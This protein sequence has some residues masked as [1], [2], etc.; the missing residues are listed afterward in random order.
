MRLSTI[1]ILLL[2][3]QTVFA[4]SE[5]SSID[6]QI[7]KIK[8][9]PASERYLLVNELKKQIAQMNALEQAKAVT[10]YQEESLKAQQ[11]AQIANDIQ[12]IN[13]MHHEQE[14]QIIT[15]VIDKPESIILPLNKPLHNDQTPIPSNEQVSPLTKPDFVPPVQ[16]ISKPTKPDFVPPVQQVNEVIQPDI[17]QDYIPQNNE[18]QTPDTMPDFT[19]QVDNM[20]QPDIVQDYVPQNDEFQ[21][22]DTM[23]DFTPQVDNVP[24]P[25][26]EQNNENPQP[27]VQQNH[28]PE[29][30]EAQPS[31]QVQ[32]YTPQI[33]EQPNS[34]ETPNNPSNTIPSIGG[35]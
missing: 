27:D 31:Q 30:E 32:N 23:P 34:A 28:T 7:A 10:K 4:G 5:T 14:Q 2:L 20:P 22:P 18:F 29:V 1:T 8:N 9:A 15:P 33:Q 17:V 3:N 13:Q 26:M 11:N 6:A 35:F 21:T 25:N 16:D 12:S 19:P 24:Q